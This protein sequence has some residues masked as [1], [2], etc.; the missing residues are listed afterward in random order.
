MWVPN[1]IS[2][3]WVDL[4]SLH[5]AFQERDAA[6]EY[7]KQRDLLFREEEQR[8]ILGLKKSQ[9]DLEEVSKRHEAVVEQVNNIDRK[10]KANLKKLKTNN[11]QVRTFTPVKENFAKLY[12]SC[13]P[14][15]SYLTS[16]GWSTFAIKCEGGGFSFP[17]LI[18]CVAIYLCI[19][20][21]Y[22]R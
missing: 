2:V 21:I 16:G 15:V 11:K 5:Q 12:E 3:L 9:E 8:L 22:W 19:F 6:I 4:K 13:F 7:L 20:R 18:I 10:Y 14:S 1:I 17:F